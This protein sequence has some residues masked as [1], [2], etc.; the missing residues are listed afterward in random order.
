MWSP[1]GSEDRVIIVL[2]FE[3]QLQ[4]CNTISYACKHS[5][6]LATRF[7]THA[8]TFYIVATRFRTRA[9]TFCTLQ[10]DFVR[11]QTRF[12]PCN[13]ILYMSKHCFPKTN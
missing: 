1:E 12:A 5:L 3:M 2:R 6:R 8:N 4:G 9:N 13:T 10:H 7:R 11:M